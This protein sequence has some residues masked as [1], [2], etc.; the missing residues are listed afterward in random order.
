MDELEIATQI[1]DM[2]QAQNQLYMAQARLMRGQ[3]AMM[4]AMAST[5]SGLNMTDFNAQVQEATDQLTAA[6]A[7]MANLGTTGAGALGGIAS[8]A[9][10]AATATGNLGNSL[11]KAGNAAMTLGAGGMIFNGFRKG[12]D[13]ALTALGS[14]GNIVQTIAEQFTNLANVI[15]TAPLVPFQAFFDFAK[16]IGPGTGEL[17]KA[18][19]EVRRTFGSLA[20][21]EGAA[22][23][24]MFK[25]LGRELG[26]T[27]LKTRRI[28]GPP[29]EQ[30]RHMLALSKSFGVQFDMV[31]NEGLIENAGNVMA[32]KKALDLSDESMKTVSRV[33]ATS[34][35]TIDEVLREQANY[36][37]QLGDAFGMSSM[38]ISRGMQEMENDMK[39]FGGLSKKTLAETTVY[40]TKLGV[41]IKS[42]ASI[43][44]AFDNFDDAA[45]AAA[46]LNQ[47]FGI[48]I[49]TLEMLRE[50]DPARRADMLRD[51]L[52]SAGISYTN[53]DRRSKSYLANQL[54]I[55]E[56]E[57]ELL[58][59]EKNRGLSLD[60]IK[61]K[62]GEAEK[63]QLTQVEVMHKLADA[64]ERLVVQGSQMEAGIFANFFKG[65][66]EGI[67]NSKAFRLIIREI[68]QIFQMAIRYGRE[69]GRAFVELFPGVK[70]ILGGFADIFNPARWKSMF[71]GVV[72]A[73]KSFFKTLQTDPEAG[74]RTLFQRLQDIFFNHFDLS[75][76]GGSK[77][78]SGFKTFFVTILK[79]IGA[80]IR[81]IVPT[82]LAGIRDGLRFINDLL[83]GRGGGGFSFDFQGMWNE[84]KTALS[85]VFS[86]FST[87]FSTVLTT[88]GPDILNA[89]TSVLSTIGNAIVPWL[90]ENW[91]TVALAV[92][93]F[94]AGPALLGAISSG[95]GAMVA[96]IFGDIA[97]G[98]FGGG[99]GGG[100][101]TSA[102]GAASAAAG[103]NA[104]IN[105]V[106]SVATTAGDWKNTIAAAVGAVI[107][108]V[109][110]VNEMQ[111]LFDAIY[112]FAGKIQ[113]GGLTMESIGSSLLI[114]GGGAL[115]IGGLISL[116]SGI[117]PTSLGTLSGLIGGG[118]LVLLTALLTGPILT[119]FGEAILQFA[120]PNGPLD[121]LLGGVSKIATYMDTMPNFEQAIGVFGT[122][123]SALGDLAYGMA[124][125]AAAGSLST[126]GTAAG[127]LLNQIS[128][129]LPGGAPAAPGATP[130]AN[131]LSQ[132]FDGLGTILTIIAD[133]IPLLIA[134]TNG[135]A[136]LSPA[137]IESRLNVLGVITTLIKDNFVPAIIELKDVAA[138]TNSA[139]GGA[140]TPAFDFNNVSV[141]IGAMI[142]SVGRL[143]TTIVESTANL[144]PE[145]VQALAGLGPV[146]N[147]A[148]TVIATIGTTVND[149]LKQTLKTGGAGAAA[150]SSFA[151]TF[152]P[153]PFERIF[154]SVG[155]FISGLFANVSL[156]E[157]MDP[158]TIA[159]I[160]VAISSI[161]ESVF[162]IINQLIAT[163]L[164]PQ[165]LE[166]VTG[167]NPATKLEALST[168]LTNI[169]DR[170]FDPNGSVL[171][172]ISSLI[173]T[174][175]ALNFRPEQASVIQAVSGMLNSI[176]NGM[177]GL[178]GA[179][180][181]VAA[182]GARADDEMPDGDAVITPLQDLAMNMGAIFS[183]LQGIL[184]DLVR[185]INEAF[186]G[187]RASTI[188]A[189]VDAVNNIIGL[190]KTALDFSSALDNFNKNN[191]GQATG[192]GLGPT[193]LER[194][195]EL[196]G[197]EPIN[198][199]T[200][201]R[202]VVSG[203]RGID[204]SRVPSLK[205]VASAIGSLADIA[206]NIT[207]LDSLT[208]I[209]IGGIAN[210]INTNLIPNLGR[211]INGIHLFTKGEMPGLD[212]ETMSGVSAVS[213][214]RSFNSSLGPQLI[215]F[216]EHLQN[217]SRNLAPVGEGITADLRDR[218]LRLTD[219]IRDTVQAVNGI[220]TVD[221]ST[222]LEALENNLG[223][224]RS[225]S[226]TISN[227]NFNLT[228]NMKVVID[229]G[230]FESVFL[231]RAEEEDPTTDTFDVG[232]FRLRPP[233]A[234]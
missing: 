114:I 129:M 119:S 32:F 11:V 142:T 100:A 159:T 213:V 230:R 222:T 45:N 82:I 15:I 40:A 83:N 57:A 99:G 184:P 148:S 198:I 29:A 43:M 115:I 149:M 74:L 171:S 70:G 210:F 133:K 101:A 84:I 162:G 205:G 128:S 201:V 85:E 104:V 136:G 232:A 76:S 220:G 186:K 187:V 161:T 140:P 94:F 103:A 21:N 58:F 166:I 62:S 68:I 6:E 35:R 208:T 228:V 110:A 48:Q 202:S 216:T 81:I 30:L 183:S 108:L 20:T 89:F 193:G 97:G 146:L 215:T 163:L 31:M 209:D 79:T 123:M 139:T 34:G 203:I 55:S 66:T 138:V 78:L 176:L 36:A 225:A 137:E 145:E 151:A 91:K 153:Q 10:A 155:V 50:E 4:E 80:A 233:P 188:N 174:V 223:L 1:R 221:L 117:N 96:S 65:F 131:P 27:G 105:S 14:V 16:S 156:F 111:S 178:I 204:T 158:T 12:I 112:E 165:I 147:G 17:R 167:E 217:V 33:A 41:E 63:K 44:D 185:N 219:T 121:M 177:A 90:K 195:N 88:Y 218:V 200:I 126:V 5:V 118:A 234:P 102:G 196:F 53:L 49:D 207:S 54:K 24:G 214:V 28:L 134:S 180:A 191:R 172:G 73:F 197:A 46:R 122:L 52:N 37:I 179:V 190:L 109:P 224:G 170:I 192:G 175:A 64:I 13:T 60:Q 92:G 23:I 86:E 2:I 157:G 9:G 181:N 150:A 135:I 125:I 38:V 71:R 182:L 75:K 189:R 226:Y 160:G 124:A 93:A 130:P 67:I 18:Y 120:S 61:K 141:F 144:R 3:L 206:T 8:G 19:E 143:L 106:G 132:A 168:F 56:A 152:D 211:I 95:I 47:Q 22:V 169:T 127:G 25:S 59:N 231:K 154:E 227:E 164:D 72:D 69:L 229:A 77:L 113:A 173:G 194:L 116:L 98:A 107:V 199:F 26:D 7:A 212:G 39:H 42:L 87:F 51:S